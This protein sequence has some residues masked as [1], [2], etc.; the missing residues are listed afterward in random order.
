MITLIT[1]GIRSG[2]SLYAEK[3]VMHCDD[4]VYIA[5]AASSDDEMKE[6]I[7]KHTKRRNPKWRTYEDYRNLQKAVGF[8]KN[9]ILDCVTNLIS[10]IL[11]EVTGTKETVSQ[12]DTEITV[13]NSI[14]ELNMLIQ[15]VKQINGNLIMVTNEVGASIVPMHPLSRCFTD[16]QG[17]V[18]AKLAEVADRV[19]LTVCG[20]PMKIKNGVE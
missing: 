3:I 19:I 14:H 10:R 18:N 13:R 4:V 8:E 9:Y 11:F 20:I 2:K 16:V 7:K 5:T 17:I 12:N 15:S 1:G 6:R